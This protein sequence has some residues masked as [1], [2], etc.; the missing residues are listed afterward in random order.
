MS[1]AATSRADDLT[2]LAEVEQA[3]QARAKDIALDMGTPAGRSA[4]R[5]LIDDEL[6]GGTTTCAA[7]AAASASPT[8][9]SSPSGLAQPR[10]YGPLTELLD[11]PDVWEIEINSPSE[12]FVKRHS[13]P[14]ATTTRAST[15]TTTSP[16]P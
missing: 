2:P 7:A 11:D 8:P 3:V 10:R 16:A 1:A 12:V 15:T 9:S 13:G 5:A 14:A 4:L 6:T